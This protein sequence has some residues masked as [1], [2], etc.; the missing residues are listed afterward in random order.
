MSTAEQYNWDG[1]EDDDGEMRYSCWPEA[2]TKSWERYMEEYKTS[3]E[4]HMQAYL[5]YWSFKEPEE[6]NRKRRRIE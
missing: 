4:M 3:S 6:H 5:R 2:A 1:T